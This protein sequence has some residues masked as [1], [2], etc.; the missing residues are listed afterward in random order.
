MIKKID[1]FQDLSEALEASTDSIKW[2]N[3]LSEGET[4]ADEDG[5]VHHRIAS[6]EEVLEEAFGELDQLDA[7]MLQLAPRKFILISKCFIKI[8][9]SK[10]LLK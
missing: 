2:A 7:A 6:P 5:L 10:L 8:E 3:V 4:A 9:I 1:L